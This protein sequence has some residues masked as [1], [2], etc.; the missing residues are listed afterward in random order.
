MTKEIIGL[1]GVFLVIGLIMFR[2]WIGAAM[3]IVGFLGLCA[4]QGFTRAAAVLGTTTFSNL[5]V[6]PIS[7]VPM[8]ALMGMVIAETNIGR[9]L[10]RAI[11]RFVGRFRGGMAS[12]TVTTAGV[13]GAITGAEDVAAVIMTKIA[14]PQMRDLGY[15]D[16]LSTASI[17][18]GSPLAIII[19]PSLP[20]ILYGIL[21]ECSVAK[22]FMGGVVPGVIMI[23]AF[24]VAISIICRI[25]PHLGP[26]GPKFPVKDR[27]KGLVG[28]APVVILFLMVLGG[29]YGGLCTTTEAGAVGA[30]GAI[31]IAFVTRQMNL[32]KFLK[33]LR[34]AV[35]TVGLILFL[36]AGTYIFI[37]FL[38]VSRLPQLLT[39]WISETFSSNFTVLLMVA[40]L[41][42]ILGMVMPQMCMMILTIPLLWPA[43]NA[44]GFNIIWFGVFV[45][46]MQALGGVTPPIGLIAYMVSGISRVSA[47]KVFRGLVP[48][49]A[50]YLLIIILVCIFPSLVTWLPSRM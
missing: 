23:G 39:V 16:E 46:M 1:I 7:A 5:S 18:G 49:I 12:A 21:T 20:M 3:A 31:I 50:A 44:L 6:Y 47:G 28:V 19:P 10:Y 45:T 25:K 26:A 9:D 8:F 13:L 17:A 48:F 42:I 36:I 37:T 30:A 29:I 43:M 2:V 11:Y 14:L 4:I 24:W 41:Y 22:M 32:K 40:I 33:I 34:E 27:L 35:V 38:N 15:D